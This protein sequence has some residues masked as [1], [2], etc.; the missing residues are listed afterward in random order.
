MSEIGPIKVK[1]RFFCRII[2]CPAA[3]GIICSNCRPSA[4]LAPSGTSSAIAC[5]IESLSASGLPR[6]PC[7]APLTRHENKHQA[8]QRRQCPDGGGEFARFHYDAVGG[9]LP[10]SHHRRHREVDQDQCKKDQFLPA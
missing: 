6:F 10:D 2:S 5:C 9:C 7:R 4:T 1:S 3:N 8:D